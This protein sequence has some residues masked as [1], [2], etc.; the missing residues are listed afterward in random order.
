MHKLHRLLGVEPLWERLL[1]VWWGLKRPRECTERVRLASR[2]TTDAGPECCGKRF[3]HGLQV[4]PNR[5]PLPSPRWPTNGTPRPRA[6]QAWLVRQRNLR[7][8]LHRLANRKIKNID[9][10]LV[11]CNCPHSF[12]LQPR[13]MIGAHLDRELGSERAAV[14]AV[15]RSRLTNG[16]LKRAARRNMRKV[17]IGATRGTDPFIEKCWSVR[18][19]PVARSRMESG[20]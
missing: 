18:V 9:A 7:C 12:A 13:V 8:I 10:L 15:W 16:S 19:I 4:E 1:L 5:W 20:P 14:N 11:Q 6:A 17:Q 2:W 3:Y